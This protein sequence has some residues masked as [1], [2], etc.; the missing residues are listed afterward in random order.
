MPWPSITILL[1][2]FWMRT[3]SAIDGRQRHLELG[4]VEQRLVVVRRDV[5]D[6]LLRVGGVAGLLAVVVDLVRAHAGCRWRPRTR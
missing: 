5:V 2:R 1:P 4:R 6:V 3:R